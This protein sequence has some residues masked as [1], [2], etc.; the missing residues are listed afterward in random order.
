MTN[1]VRLAPRISW[2]LAVAAG[3]LAAAGCSVAAGGSERKGEVSSALSV[4]GSEILGFETPA[5]WKITAGSGTLS[6]SSI[7]VQGNAS[8]ALAQGIGTST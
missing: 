7:R 2:I 6:A 5:G 8:L 3:G 4:A 1:I